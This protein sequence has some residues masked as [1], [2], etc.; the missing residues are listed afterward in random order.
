MRSL[1]LLSGNALE[2]V[3]ELLD[4]ASRVD[5]PLFTSVSGM[6]IHRHVTEDDEIFGTIN[7]LLAG[8]F[9][10]GLGHET[11]AGSDIEEADVIER[12]MAF[13]FHSGKE[14]LISLGAL[15]N[16]ARLC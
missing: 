12:G 10:R 8:R 5:K 1:L 9:H 4:A 13:G 2:L 16:A 14:G 6:R 15:C 7:A 11:F 3:R